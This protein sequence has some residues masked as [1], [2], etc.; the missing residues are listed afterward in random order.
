MTRVKPTKSDEQ[1]IEKAT[2]RY[3][4]ISNRRSIDTLCN[5]TLTDRGMGQNILAGL[6]R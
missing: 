2:S 1:D 5:Q 4:P 3:A 6:R